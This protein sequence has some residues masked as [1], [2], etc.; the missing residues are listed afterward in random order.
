MVNLIGHISYVK[1]FFSRLIWY[2]GIAS[3]GNETGENLDAGTFG[4]N[5]PPFAR[6]CQ[7]G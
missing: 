7:E 5:A 6:L 3:H 1:D 4:W 2:A